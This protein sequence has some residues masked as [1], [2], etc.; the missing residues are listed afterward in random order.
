MGRFLPDREKL[1]LELPSVQGWVRGETEASDLG[2]GDGLHLKA[3]GGF[4][5]ALSL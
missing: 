2:G 4:C 5:V 3:R 1:D